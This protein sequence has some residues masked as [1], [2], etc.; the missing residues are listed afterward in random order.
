MPADAVAGSDGAFARA[1]EHITTAFAVTSGEHHTIVY[2]NSVFRDLI[3]ADGRV[4][5][6]LPI[7]DAI[8]MRDTS[9]LTALLDHTLRAGVVSRNVG[10]GSLN[11]R[12][13]PLSCTVWPNREVDSESTHLVLE[14]RATTPAPRALRLQ[15]EI[16]ERLLM[17]ALREHDAA[18]LAEASRERATFLAS[19]SRRLS[20]SLD[21]T[22]TLAAMRSI[23][24]PLLNAWCIVDT[25]SADGVTRALT[26]PHIEP[27]RQSIVERLE[28]RWGPD[29]TGDHELL[30][31]MRNGLPWVVTNTVGLTLVGRDDTN[32][33]SNGREHGIGPLL[34][35]PMLVRN[36]LIGALTFVGERSDRPFTDEE[37]ELALDLAIRA[38]TALDRARAYGEAVA[39]KMQAESASQAKSTFLGMMSHELRTP[40]NAIGGYVD[41]IDLELHGPVTAAQRHDLERIRSSQQYLTRLISD[42]LNMTKVNSGLS[43]Y[44]DHDILMQE[45]LDRSVALVEP[46]FAKKLQ[47]LEIVMPD[48]RIMARGDREKVTQIIVNLLS[49][50]VKFTS[51]EGRIIIACEKAADSVL[52]RITDNGIGI[53]PGKLKAIFEPFVQI[54][55]SLVGAEGGIGLGLAISRSLARGMHGDV[56]VES[57][58]G[59]GSTFTL[60]LPLERRSRSV[61]R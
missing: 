23:C 3:A 28:G 50:S 54:S 27:D 25:F 52:L 57:T 47:R 26:I 35:V 44:D 53:A 1:I 11:N 34:T 17:S 6:G 46:L 37:I 48:K 61:S 29:G 40:L 42:L 9:E 14:L 22:D 60:T 49:N 59:R 30:V 21:E 19:E 18:D 51:A 20:E 13:E 12:R 32:E 24:L 36:T 58:L 56:T 10:V 41:I 33:Q 2:T 39:L 16:S 38:A 31:A 7:A 55:E 5:L 8:P 4:L 45:V 43:V 15:R